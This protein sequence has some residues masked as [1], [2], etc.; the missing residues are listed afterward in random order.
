MNGILEPLAIGCVVVATCT[1]ETL[2]LKEGK[3]Y[4]ITERE[5]KPICPGGPHRW[6]YAIDGGKDCFVLEEMIAI[7]GPVPAVVA[8]GGK[9]TTFSN[10]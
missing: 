5:S 6:F 7:A 3:R 1:L 2:P 9:Q 4:T 8:M 10:L